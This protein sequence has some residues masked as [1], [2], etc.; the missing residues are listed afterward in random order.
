MRSDCLDSFRGFL[1]LTPVSK[2]NRVQRPLGK[3]V[4]RLKSHSN[5]CNR[6]PTW[7][8]SQS[9]CRRCRRGSRAKC[10]G[11]VAAVAMH[12][13]KERKI[14]VSALSWVRMHFPSFSFSLAF[15]F[16]SF[17]FYFFF[18]LSFSR[19]NGLPSYLKVHIHSH[20]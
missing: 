16:F 8:L 2:S 20:K 6:C 11:P 4:E 17:S 14:N 1:V 18:S 19:R 13:T 10:R 12:W 3:P 5:V 7:E 9:T 15:N